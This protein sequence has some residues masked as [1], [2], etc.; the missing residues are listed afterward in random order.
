MNDR[1]GGWLALAAGVVLILVAVLADV[2]GYGPGDDSFGI[3]QIIVTII[4]L[5]LAG[6]GV[7]R[8]L[9]IRRNL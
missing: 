2:V 7:R 3:G 5:A 4:G 6:Y 9:Q 1:E 8:L